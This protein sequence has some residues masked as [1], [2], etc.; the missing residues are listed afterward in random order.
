MHLTVRLHR[1]PGLL[2]RFQPPV[3]ERN[4]KLD[5][6][7]SFVTRLIDGNR[8]TRAIVA[9]FVTRY[10]VTTREAELSCIQFLKLLAARHAVSIIVK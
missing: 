7:G 3:M 4:I 8:G 10:Q 9:A 5:E 6:L 1:K 2:S